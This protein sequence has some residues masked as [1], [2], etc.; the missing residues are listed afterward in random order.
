MESLLRYKVA[1]MVGTI[2]LGIGSFLACLCADETMIMTGNVLLV[3][4][5]ICMAYGYSKWQP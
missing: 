3:I 5:I 1:S 4:G 2:I